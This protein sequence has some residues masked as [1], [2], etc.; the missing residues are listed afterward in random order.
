[1]WRFNNKKETH[2]RIYYIAKLWFHI[3]NIKTKIGCKLYDLCVVYI[4]C[5]H[6]KRGSSYTENGNY[7]PSGDGYTAIW[8][9]RTVGY[10]TP[11]SPIRRNWPSSSDWDTPHYAKSGSVVPHTRPI[12]GSSHA[13]AGK[14]GYNWI[15]QGCWL[16]L[17][18]LKLY[19]QCLKRHEIN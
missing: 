16:W 9:H 10:T 2:S 11:S 18:T 4:K 14:R 19:I 13:V 15:T 17:T 6:F 1:M 7:S 12:R 8:T 3:N 5:C